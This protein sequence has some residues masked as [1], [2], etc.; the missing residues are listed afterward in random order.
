VDVDKVVKAVSSR[1]ATGQ[2]SMEGSLVLEG[3]QGSN[4]ARLLSKARFKRAA[5]P[6]G[7]SFLQLTPEGKD[8]YLLV[9]NGQKSWAFVPKLKKYTEEEASPVSAAALGSE[10]APGAGSTDER[11]SAEV[12][13][14]LIVESLADLFKTA[15]AADVHGTGQ[16]KF[17]GR[18]AMWPVVRVMSKDDPRNGRNLVELT[19]DP[20]TL[21]IGRLVW[22]N[23]TN[24]GGE[25][26]VLRMT[27]EYSQ[28]RL[29]EPVDEAT[30]QFS[31]PKNAKLVD[32]VPIPGQTGSFL[33]NQTAPDFELKT[34]EGE[35]VR[36]SELRGKP[37]VLNFWASW[38]G[39]CR[40][41][42]PELADLYDS[43]KDKGLVLYG[44]NDEGK[45]A[46]RAF[47][48]KAGLSFPTLDDYSLK[49]HRLYRVTA[50]PTMFIIDREGKIVR[51]LRGS[52]DKAKLAAALKSVGF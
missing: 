33:L 31:P 20:A 5:A 29:G 3:R 46:A 4:P 21:S 44:V 25:Q 30:F 27:V 15:Q 19:I 47:A 17:E 9:S 41:E 24:K 7:K 51:F 38:C 36:L 16:V 1:A 23:I 10:E 37:V 45:G 12:F 11:D 48:Q 49:A 32:A 34:L 26:T 2:Y 39:P 13:L 35:R 42:L 40:K 50:V 18:K 14:G 52:Q 8:E 43:L 28:F 22:A 6:G